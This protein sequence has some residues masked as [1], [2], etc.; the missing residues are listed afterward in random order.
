MGSMSDFEF[1][2][3]L[4]QQTDAQPPSPHCTVGVE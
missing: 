4:S 3:K 1:K 2:T